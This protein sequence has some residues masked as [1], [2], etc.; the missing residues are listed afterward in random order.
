MLYDVHLIL[1]GSPSFLQEWTL[2]VHFAGGQVIAALQGQGTSENSKDHHA[3]IAEPTEPTGKSEKAKARKKPSRKSSLASSSVSASNVAV[4]AAEEFKDAKLDLSRCD[5]LVV[6]TGYR[7][8]A[9]VLNIMADW[10]VPVLGSNWIV[11]CLLQQKRASH[12]L[13]ILSWG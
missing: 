4:P 10:E 1:V 8:A 7:P 13:H 3:K 2:L 6:E 9:S 12:R 11:E 5:C